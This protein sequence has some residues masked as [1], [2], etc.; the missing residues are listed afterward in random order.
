MRRR[1]AVRV[2]YNTGGV[3]FDTPS[4]SLP[5]GSYRVDER[6]VLYA[7]AFDA[8]YLE[9]AK[10]GRTRHI[11]SPTV[12]SYRFPLAKRVFGRAVRSKVGLRSLLVSMPSRVRF[13]VQRAQRREV[14]FAMRRAGY[15][16]S[17]PKGR[18][19]RNAFSSYRC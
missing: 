14:L 18:Y 11:S 10:L 16:G 5:R 7:P 19:R 6:D 1:R 8:V 4:V 15:A 13:C 12:I 17:A 9:G 3:Q 2:G